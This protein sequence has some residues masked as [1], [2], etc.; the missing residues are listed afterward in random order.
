VRLA[1]TVGGVA[2]TI[3]ALVTERVGRVLGGQY[4]LDRRLRVGGRDTVYLGSD[5]GDRRRVLVRMPEDAADRHVA[6]LELFRERARIRKFVADPTLPAV[7]SVGDDDDGVPFLVEVATDETLAFAAKQAAAEPEAASQ[8]AVRVEPSSSPSL[9]RLAPRR[10]SRSRTDQERRAAAARAEARFALEAKRQR[11]RASKRPPGDAATPHPDDVCAMCGGTPLS[12]K[13]VCARCGWSSRTGQRR[14][15][16]PGCGGLVET[17]YDV[18]HLRYP[19]GAFALVA[20]GVA[21]L[22]GWLGSVVVLFVAAAVASVI[23]GSSF[24]HRCDSCGTPPPSRY[25]GAGESKYQR[26]QRAR[27]VVRGGLFGLASLV[28][29][30][31][32]LVSVGIVAQ[33]KHE[34]LDL[35]GATLGAR[36]SMVSSLAAQ[37]REPELRRDA[38]AA[39]EE[40]GDRA[41]PY[42]LPLLAEG[43]AAQKH[44]ALEVL[45]HLKPR[46]AE[47]TRRIG[48]FV[49]HEEDDE[50][51]RMGVELLSNAGPDAV[52]AVPSLEPLLREPELCPM[53]REA[54][55]RID[56][57]TTRTC[58]PPR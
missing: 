40:M 39:M 8:S 18:D 37:L 16:R 25:L 21:S 11:L 15:L 9:D 1:W 28:A 6:D 4:R 13:G 10:P 45:H 7:L 31:F 53:V 42:M 56:P 34:G 48:E 57:E 29:T 43:D 52:A 49:A 24:A 44:A 12:T 3:G 2:S 50:L 17:G 54:L 32:W 47:S 41:V 36:A 27:Y 35:R 23:V 5:I 58:A 14:C 22:G 30:W 55:A 38:V 19:G 33:K 46:G 51:R 26:D 20:I